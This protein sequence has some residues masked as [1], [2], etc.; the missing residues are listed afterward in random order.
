[1]KASWS[2]GRRA[3][4]WGTER[5][6]K[7]D[8]GSATA[9][10]EKSHSPR[11]VALPA[12]RA[13]QRTSASRFPRRLLRLHAHRLIQLDL[14]R[15]TVGDAPLVVRSTHGDGGAGGGAGGGA[16]DRRLRVVAEDL[17]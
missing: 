10:G 3:G 11:A 13:R 8:A 16:D 4:R 7:R 15:A 1:M 9:R 12:A 6:G 17:A 2:R 5:R 14:D